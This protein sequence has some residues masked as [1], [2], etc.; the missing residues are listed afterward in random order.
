M[1]E[2]E[3]LRVRRDDA[4]SRLQKSFAL[5]DLWPDCFEHGSVTAYFHGSPARGF[6]FTIQRSD[7]EYRTFPEIDV[8]SIIARPEGEPFDSLIRRRSK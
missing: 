3:D 6:F 4:M 1:S 8:P 5:Q 2:V 7:G